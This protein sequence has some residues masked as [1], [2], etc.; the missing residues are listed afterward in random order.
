MANVL[1]E[2]KRIECII[3]D[4][5]THCNIFYKSSE[6]GNP[7]WGGGWKTKSYPKS[8]SVVNIFNDPYGIAEYMMWSNGR[9]GVDES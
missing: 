7:F 5:L 8:A 1:T 9:A 3:E 4:E 2:I 6:P